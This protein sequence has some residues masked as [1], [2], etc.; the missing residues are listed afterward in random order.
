MALRKD[1]E[2]NPRCSECDS[3]VRP[4]SFLAG[5]AALASTVDVFAWVLAGLFLALAWVWPPAYLVAALTVA[6]GV[7]KALGRRPRYVCSSCKRG[8]T[9]DQVH[10]K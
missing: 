8:F 2:G 10:G 5:L 7:S 4:K 1:P 3:A 9:Y 6:L